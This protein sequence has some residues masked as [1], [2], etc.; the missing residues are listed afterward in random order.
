MERATIEELKNYFEIIDNVLVRK[1]K[2]GSRG[3]VGD[4]ITGTTDKDNRLRIKFKGKNYQ[5][6]RVIWQMTIGEIPDNMFID[7]IDGNPGNNNITN[8]RLATNSNNNHNIKINS[9]NTTGYKDIVKYSKT[10]NNNTYY[11]YKVVVKLNSK[12]YTKN[13]EYSEIGLLNAIKYRNFLI[14][15]LHKEFGRLE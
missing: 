12:Q 15:Q 8:L 6:S 7:H 4:I 14:D 13:F 2:S 5:L 3:L 9:N 11:Y 10:K 1:K